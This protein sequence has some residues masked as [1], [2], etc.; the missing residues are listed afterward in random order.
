MGARV[1][2]PL[3][4]AEFLRRLGIEQRAAALKAGAPAAICRPRSSA[5]LERLTNED[6]TG[7][8]G[9]IKAI[10]LSDPKLESCPASRPE[11]SEAAKAHPWLVRGGKSRA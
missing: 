4:Q 3:A 7:M 1:H 5:A 9:L 8:G 6:R 11:Q 10:A 2:G